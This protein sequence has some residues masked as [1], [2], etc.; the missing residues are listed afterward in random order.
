MI[1]RKFKSLKE[2]DECFA[3]P[4][5]LW[6]DL[7]CYKCKEAPIDCECDDRWLRLHKFRVNLS[8]ARISVCLGHGGDDDL[9]LTRKF[10]F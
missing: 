2:I 8:S 5:L 3:D 4:K 10:G 6:Y 1:K 9:K 7:I